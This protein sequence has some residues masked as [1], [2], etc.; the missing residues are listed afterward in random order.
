MTAVNQI[1]K[2]LRVYARTW[3]FREMSEAAHIGFVRRMSSQFAESFKG[4]SDETV[5]EAVKADLPKLN[6]INRDFWPRFHADKAE[7][8]ARECEEAAM[9][10]LAERNA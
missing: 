1:K 10:V 8:H 7:L 5:W 6:E 2:E 9:A 3:M 4:I